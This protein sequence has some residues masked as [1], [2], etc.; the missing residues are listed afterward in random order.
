ML[1]A[2]NHECHQRS[3]EP[4]SPICLVPDFAQSAACSAHPE[5]SAN[6]A[7]DYQTSSSVWLHGEGSKE[8]IS[9]PFIDF[10]GIGAT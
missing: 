4:D 10:L 5:G 2:G 9:M 7:S 3:A 1:G 8:K 6:E